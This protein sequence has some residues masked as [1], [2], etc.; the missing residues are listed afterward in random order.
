MKRVAIT[1]VSGYLGRRLLQRLEEEEGVERIIGISRNPPRHASS[2]LSFFSRDVRESFRDI[3]AENDVDSA[4]HLAFVTKSSGSNEEAARINI[5]G[6]ENFL[7]ACR[8]DSVQWLMYLSTSSVYGACP[9]NPV[10]LTEEAPL[11]TPEGH[12]YAQDKKEGEKLFLN[13]M[14]GHPEKRVAIL[15]CCPVIGPGGAGSPATFS[16][17]STIMVRY[18]GYDPLW[19]FLHEDDVVE[20]MVT[21][22]RQETGGVFNVASDE[23]LPYSEVISLLGS[24]GLP[25]PISLVKAIEGAFRILHLHS[26]SPVSSSDFIRY[27]VVLSAE[28]LRKA[29]G[30]KCRYSS[31]EAL[32]SYVGN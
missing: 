22:A 14:E 21:L 25:L 6:T 20:S 3:F 10:P 19:Q 15:R 27:P 30:F 24:R 26:R 1:G 32:K 7:E 2:K 23:G 12:R 16:F 28:K 9:D 13:F 8:R 29:T 18:V 17:S 11:R 31:R 4:F 5:E